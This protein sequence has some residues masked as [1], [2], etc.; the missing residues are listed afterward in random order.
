MMWQQSLAS[1][2][3][4]LEKLREEVKHISQSKVNAIDIEIKFHEIYQ[5]LSELEDGKEDSSARD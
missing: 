4:I 5:K 1:N 3:K 2:A